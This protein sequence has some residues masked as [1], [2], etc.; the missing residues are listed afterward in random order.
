MDGG[1][2]AAVGQ[3]AV[4]RLN[5]S[6]EMLTATA[7]CDVNAGEAVIIDTPGGGGFGDPN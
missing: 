5:G 4:K 7:R 3:N 2:P 1:H 6:R